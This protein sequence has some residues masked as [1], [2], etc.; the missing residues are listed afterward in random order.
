MKQ[1]FE[2]KKHRRQRRFDSVEV[3]ACVDDEAQRMVMKK[4]VVLVREEA[5]V[6]SR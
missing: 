3:L 4:G 6:H 5:M 2:T 1:N